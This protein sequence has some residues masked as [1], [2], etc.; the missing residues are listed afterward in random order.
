MITS[1]LLFAC[2][3]NN[4]DQQATDEDSLAN[5]PFYWQSYLDDS[6]GK[7]EYRKLPANDTLSPQNVLLYLN[8]A[9]PNIGL[10]L[11]NV[12]ADTI[13]LRIPDAM[14]LTQQMGSTGPM[15]YLSEVVYNFT[16]IPG[17]KEVNFD[18]DEGDHATP[19]TYNRNTFTKE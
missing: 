17:I 6:T 8:K 14:Y 1:A 5:V 9:Y 11:K 3:N 19:G 7:I 15:I 12:T 18:F 4:A 10:E 2:R 13:Y 16:E